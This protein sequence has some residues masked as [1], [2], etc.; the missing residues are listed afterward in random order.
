[1]GSFEIVCFDVCTA[2]LMIYCS[3]CHNKL[4]HYFS[5]PYV[6]T[7]SIHELVISKFLSRGT[8]LRDYKIVVLN[9]IF[10]YFNTLF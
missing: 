8:D 9:K 10:Y 1:M 4:S 2:V 5:E 6:K 3:V 7:T